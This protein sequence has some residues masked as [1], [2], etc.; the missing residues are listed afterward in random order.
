MR[1]PARV[2]GP[3]MKRLLGSISRRGS[4]Y[5]SGFLRTEVSRADLPAGQDS[6]DVVNTNTNDDSP[7]ANISR[8]VVSIQYK[9]LLR[10]L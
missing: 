3:N 5:D 2:P 8:G 7:E 4:A 6:N 1:H 10:Y 9:L